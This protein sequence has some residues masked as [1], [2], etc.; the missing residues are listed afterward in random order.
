MYRN[1]TLKL[2]VRSVGSVF[3]P[4][5]YVFEHTITKIMLMTVPRW[6]ED[7]IMSS[8][9][10]NYQIKK[11]PISSYMKSVENSKEFFGVINETKQ[12]QNRS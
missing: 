3:L 10:N 11:L 6:T 1:V 7:I 2:V 9:Q 4:I 5:L 12:T 8:D